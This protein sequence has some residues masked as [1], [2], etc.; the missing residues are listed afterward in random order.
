M[1]RALACKN[2]CLSLQRHVR[3]LENP[4]VSSFLH[5][6]CVH[7]VNQG[8]FGKVG[9][10]CYNGLAKASDSFNLLKRIP[11]K[12][13]CDDRSNSPINLGL[14][15]QVSRPNVG[16]FAAQIVNKTPPSLQPY[17]KLMRLDKPIGTWLLYWPCGWSIAM[18]APPGSLPDF[19]MLAL[20]GL[21][22]VVMRGAGCTI[23]DMWDK[24]IDDK[25][26][27]TKDRP[28]VS[29]ALSTSDALVFLSGQLGLGLLILLQL[30]WYSVLLGASSLVA[31]SGY[32]QRRR[33]F[34]EICIQ[35]ICGTTS[36][37]WNIIG[38]PPEGK[39]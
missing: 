14:K 28:L 29:G 1:L 9:A 12:Y 36:L 38:D 20:F 27:R 6:K 23:N 19:Y 5:C 16:S 2:L 25:V 21:G 22:A 17:L 24:D 10:R 30:N 7:S 3:I 37:H 33:L 4:H 32:K 26:S 31:D 13:H 8:R 35:Q 39:A 15:T 11:N 18:S 34:K